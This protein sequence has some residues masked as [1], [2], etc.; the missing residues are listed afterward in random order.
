MPESRALSKFSDHFSRYIPLS[1]P[2]EEP[3][4]RRKTRQEQREDQQRR[5]TTAQLSRLKQWGKPP[6]KQGRPYR[7]LPPYI[8][9]MLLQDL[10][11]SM[12]YREIIKKWA[13]YHL[14]L[15]WISRAVSSGDLE[16]MVRGEFPGPPVREG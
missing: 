14:S 1:A 3:A 8:A 6:P 9:Q 10:A 15:A 4:A 7:I 2:P 16:R 12:G 5:E 13:E 11:E